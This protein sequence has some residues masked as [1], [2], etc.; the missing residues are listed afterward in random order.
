M[1]RIQGF[2]VSKMLLA[3]LCMSFIAAGV[4]QAQSDLSAFTGKFTLTNQ[5]LWGETVL[6]PGNYTITIPSF[7][8]ATFALVRDGKGRPVARFMSRIDD[9]KTSSRNALLIG[10]KNGRLHVYSLQ[11]AALGRV[12]VY[13]RA[14]AREAVREARAPQTV[15]VMLAKR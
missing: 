15:Q 3:A 8:G 1:K 7:S 11:L 2:E 14:L 13:D 12:L 4:V 9:R 5:V 6:Q 10:E